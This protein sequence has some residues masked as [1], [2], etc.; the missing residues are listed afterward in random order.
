MGHD[1]M[2]K[3]K[4]FE[5]KDLRISATNDEGE[6]VKIVKGVSFDIHKGEVV[7]LIGESGSGKTTISLATLAYTKPGLHFSGGE[8]QLYG[9]DVLTMAPVEQ[10]NLRGGNVAYLAQSAAATFNPAITIN[11]QVT[12]AAVLHGRLTQAEADKRAIEL[13][14]ALELPDADRIGYR[15]PHQVS[16]GQ[17]QRLMAAMALCGKPDLLVLD[18]P[19]T[20]LDVTTQIEVLKAFKKVIREENSAAVYVTHDL[21][22]VAQVADHIV[23][24]YSG[25]VMEQGS[26]DQIINHPTHAYTK[27]LMAAVR[28]IPE[29]GQGV[30]VSG[31]HD[32][33]IDNMEVKNMTAGYGGIVD[34][35][36]V[37]PILKDI[38]ISVK[39]GHV[40]GVIGESGCG[41]STMA[42][43]MAGMLPPAKGDIILDGKKLEGDLHDRKLS[44]LQ[45]VQF[46]FQMADTALNPKQLIGNIIGRPL[47]FYHGLKGRE[48]HAK[49]AEILDLVELPAAFA[50]RYPMELSG[51]QKQRINLA[52][53]L[54]AN[55][56]V[57]LC[58]EVT[59]ALDSIVGA[60]VIKLLTDLRD[61]TGVSFVFI[62]HDLSTVASFADE[63]VVLYAGRVVEQGPT[64]EVLQ[65]PFHPYTR[66]LISSV[67][68]MRIGWLEDTMQKREMAVGIARGV[69]ITKHGCPFYNRCPMAIEGTCDTVIPPIIELENGHQIACHISLDKLLETEAETQKILHGYEKLGEDAP[70]VV[71]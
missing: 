49:V 12:E 48:K 60:N 61:K 38:N 35:E 51:G 36:P 20:A 70:V 6:E 50:N 19:T 43:V 42:R 71:P 24:L 66:L 57:M 68:E 2:N 47:E 46:V 34:G 13:Y 58:D 41:K 44:E 27:R 45:K 63:I 21:A 52:R 30:E 62:S 16:G 65:P 18:E 1:D 37:V 29:A 10:R 32:R 40:V 28:P 67:P 69:E 15:Y 3:E 31:D 23:V 22:V 7:A 17:L 26:V 11:E 4:L 64:D 54:A 56:E 14:H 8:C 53:S 5:V 59:S 9:K 25:E 55:P 33:V 39:N